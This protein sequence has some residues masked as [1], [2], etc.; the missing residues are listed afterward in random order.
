MKNT[1]L[2]LLTLTAATF[3][4]TD[5][6]AAV[7]KGKVTVDDPSVIAVIDFKGRHWTTH[8]NHLD[9]TYLIQPELGAPEIMTLFLTFPDPETGEKRQT[10]SP[11]YVEENSEPLV[12][13]IEKNGSSPI[14]YSD[15]KN[16]KAFFDFTEFLIDY[17]RNPQQGEN[18]NIALDDIGN[19]INELKENVDNPLVAGYLELWGKSSQAMVERLSTP[20][21]QRMAPGQRPN[22]QPPFTLEELVNNPAT[23][24]FPEFVNMVTR[25]AVKG[26]T[27]TES[28]ASLKENVPEGELRDYLE[29]RLIV[30]YINN[31]KGKM[32]AEE[33]IAQ[34]DE[35]A[36]DMPEYDKWVKSI[37]D[38]RPFLNRG[39]KAPDDILIAADGTEIRLSDLKGKYVFIDFWASW[40]TYCVKEIPALEKIKEEFADSDIQ[41]IGI[42]L[43]DNVEAWKEAMK[44]HG[45]NE[46]QYIVSSKELAS[47]LGLSSIP[48]YMIY[49]RESKMLYP[50][51]PR[52][53]Q[54]D[55]LTDLLKSL[56]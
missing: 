32:P 36:K 27:L 31:K 7:I 49:D 45:L 8:V 16:E 39:E 2:A 13:N 47:K 55:K 26:N 5:A 4:I 48:R 43:D 23:K 44:K 19:K 28:I 53:R 34:I 51:A 56:S 29:T 10:Y 38:Y 22:R 15:S 24:Y 1:F 46:N 37:K 21:G 12:I 33:L 41:F 9:S 17:M 50:E 40:C 20:R 35:V 11:I 14:F 52:P 42:S 25:Q 3:G 30:Q 54:Y 18:V 6:Q